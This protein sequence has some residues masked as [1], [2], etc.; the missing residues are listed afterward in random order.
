MTQTHDAPTT[1]LDAPTSA[2]PDAPTSAT[3]FVGTGETQD[4]H[5]DALGRYQWGWSDSDVAGSTA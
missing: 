5:L 1:L 4:Q 2:L 3:G